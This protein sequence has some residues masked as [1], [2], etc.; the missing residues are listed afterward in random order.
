MDGPSPGESDRAIPSRGPRSCLRGG[1]GVRGAEGDV[2]AVAV[3]GDVEG[4]LDRCRHVFRRLGFVGQRDGGG[5]RPRRLVEPAVDLDLRV[6]AGH[7]VDRPFRF[8]RRRGRRR[9]DGESQ[10]HDVVDRR[11]AGRR[12]ADIE[13][14]DLAQG[15]CRPDPRARCRPRP[16]SRRGA[17]RLRGRS[18]NGAPSRR[19][20]PIR[21]PE[22]RRRL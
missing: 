19:S 8:R 15:C 2:E 18:G 12:S 4:R 21:R 20:R 5:R 16:G 17:R 22:G 11:P 7:V 14:E 1:I 9:R 13:V 6:G 10:R 3:V